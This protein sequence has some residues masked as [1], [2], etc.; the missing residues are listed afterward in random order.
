M[1]ESPSECLSY[2]ELSSGELRQGWAKERQQGFPESNLC[3]CG[4]RAAAEF[5]P[6]SCADLRWVAVWAKAAFSTE[7]GEALLLTYFATPQST[8]W[9][10]MGDSYCESN[11][12]SCVHQPLW[13]WKYAESNVVSRNTFE[14]QEFYLGIKYERVSTFS[15]TQRLFW[16]NSVCHAA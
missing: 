5:Q 7:G 2:T 6:V 16:F 15:R 13:L 11:C 12:K 1:W 4:H 10:H 9:I 8:D 14:C 3:G